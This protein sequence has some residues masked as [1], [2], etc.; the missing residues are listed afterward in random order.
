MSSSQEIEKKKILVRFLRRGGQF[1]YQHRIIIEIIDIKEA[2]IYQAMDD[3][4]AEG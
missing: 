1:F 4:E 2:C 3:G